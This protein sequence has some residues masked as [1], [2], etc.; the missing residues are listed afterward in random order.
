[1]WQPVS[2]HLLYLQDGFDVTVTIFQ[3]HLLDTYTD[4]PPGELPAP[5][6]LCI[7]SSVSLRF[8]P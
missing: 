3:Q 5:L 8:F 7:A 2:S 4:T 1:M 6:L